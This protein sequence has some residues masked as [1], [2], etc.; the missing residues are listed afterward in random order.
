[1]LNL[2]KLP[3]IK[4]PDGFIWGSAT[5]GHQIE[6]NNSN[7]QRWF[8]EL[9]D[10]KLYEVPSGLACNGYKL[11]R[12]DIALLKEL[13]HQGYRFSI[14]WSRIQPAEGDFSETALEHYLD[15][16]HLLKESG[17]HSCVTLHHFTHPQW[18][19]Q[20][21]GFSKEENLDDWKRYLEYLIPK[22]APLVDSWCILNEFNLGG[23]SNL[24][25]KICKLKAHGFGY[26]IIK[27]H[28]NAPATSAHAFIHRD[29]K[30]RYD[31]MDIALASYLDWTDNE[32][33]FHAIRTG[34][35]VLP[36]HDMEYMP[37][38]KGASDFWGINFYTRAI[39]DSRTKLGR[40]RAFDF[41]RFNMIDQYF[42]KEEFTPESLIHNLSRL[43]DLPIWITENGACCDDDRFRIISL[44]MHL[45]ALS[46]AAKLYGLDIRAYFYWSLMDNYEWRTFRPRFGLVH[47]DFETFRRTPKPSAY[48]YREI[49]ERN[50]LDGDLFAKYLPELPKL[51]L[52][53]KP[54]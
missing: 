12:E 5:A 35:I 50:S 14:E 25:E 1:M 39:I 34:E 29:P 33:F 10:P 53:N 23:D 31:P 13:K 2:Y 54:L 8:M 36:F 24:K 19:E 27:A 26:R 52:Y 4:F 20:K 40:G 16:L 9:A 32:F 15:E 42:Y 7:A 28:S 22:I 51:T 6:G 44:A 46:E 17:I 18:F 11:Y 30:R 45:S 21:G 47:V 48:F 49:I 41:N 3:E 37:E 43:K 38:L